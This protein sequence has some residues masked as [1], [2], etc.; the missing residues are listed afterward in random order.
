MIQQHGP[1]MGALKA[2]FRT[3][4]GWLQCVLDVPPEGRQIQESALG[5]SRPGTVQGSS[6]PPDATVEPQRGKQGTLNN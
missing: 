4:E 2:R 3:W 5:L 6:S 1:M